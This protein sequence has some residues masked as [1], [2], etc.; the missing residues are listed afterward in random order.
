MQS[1]SATA[2]VLSFGRYIL[3]R[4]ALAQAFRLS[5]KVFQRTVT[6]RRMVEEA[7]PNFDIVMHTS[8]FR[9]GASGSE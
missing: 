8:S 5:L 3:K 1:A 7:M 6:K 2:I 9:D 4:V